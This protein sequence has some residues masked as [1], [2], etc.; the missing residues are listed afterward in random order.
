ME[1]TPSLPLIIAVDDENDDIF[2]LKQILKKTE[3]AH[4]FQ[5]FA[6][7]EAALVALTALMGENNTPAFPLVCFL[8]LKMIGMSG[9]DLLSGIRSQKALDTLPVFMF[10]SS[11]R[12][13]DVEQ[14]RSLN[15][16]G[17]LKKYPS[18]EAM[19]KVLE[20][21]REFAATDPAK[22]TFLQ[23]SYRFIGTPTALVA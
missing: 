6:N 22:K 17:Y 5:P 16:Q 8:D 20:E 19:R 3:F 9:F 13:Q 21:A 10:S 15:A 18:A 7:G 2:F 4:R 11:D 1:S 12:P 23:W 14:A